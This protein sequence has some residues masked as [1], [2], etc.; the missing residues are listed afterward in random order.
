MSILNCLIKQS[1]H[2][3]NGEQ[4]KGVRRRYLVINRLS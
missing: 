2:C 1:R 4:T 3:I